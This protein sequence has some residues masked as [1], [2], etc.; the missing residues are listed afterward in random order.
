MRAL[1]FAVVTFLSIAGCGGEA[2]L[3]AGMPDGGPTCTELSWDGR[4]GSISRWPEPLMLV[5][6]ATTETGRRIQFDPSSDPDLL[7]RLGD[8]ASV[9]S[10]D[11]GTVDGFGINAE[12]FFRFGRA[13]DEAM[14][15]SGD[16][17]ASPTAGIG[18]V[19]FDP[20][21]ARIVPAIVTTTDAGAT[22]MLAPMRPLPARGRAAAFVTRAL[23]GAAGGCLEPS[24]SM[25]DLFAAP[26]A[27]SGEAIAALVSLG[28]ITGTADLVA[29]TAF[30]TQSIEEDSIA[31]AADVAAR[32]YDFVAPPTCTTEATWRRCEASFVAQDYRDQTDLVFRRAAGAPAMPQATYE[33]PVTFWL[34]LSGTPPYPTMLF[35]HG[36]SGDR[37]QAERLAGFAAPMGMA[38]FAIDAQAHGDHPT[39]P[40]ETGALATLFEF[41]AIM[42]SMDRALEAA[43]LRDNFRASSWDKLQLTRLVLAHPDIDGDG[44]DD[45]DT[46]RLAYLGVSLGGLMGPEPLAISDAYGAGVLVVPGGRVS[47][48]ISDG[49]TFGPLVVAL[50][51]RGTTEG[52]IRRFFPILQTVI[53][54]GDPASYAPHVLEDRFPIASAATPSVLAGVVL[55]DAI[56]PNVSNYVLGRALGVPMVRLVLDPQ[57]GYADVAGPIMGNFSGGAATGGLLQFDVIGDGMGGIVP[58]DHGNVGASDVGAAAWLD[59]LDTHFRTGLARIRDPYAAI[60]LPHAM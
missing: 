54:R 18:F 38:T 6:D 12:A 31:V 22:L 46:T 8:Y 42:R 19:V 26:D 30:P 23:T 9:F 16:A 52:D 32:S 48:I 27:D 7:R 36:L 29:L 51:P 60:G 47:A 44:T 15:P 34:P 56:V 49:E 53:E 25:T 33:L 39:A 28:A 43:R 40:I 1:P 4:V 59:F 14:I 57:P 2:S 41:F 37:Y 5:D 13:F 10:M 50:R 17:T 45:V 24:P 55:D 21:P 11:L 58:A 35:G 3:D 20:A